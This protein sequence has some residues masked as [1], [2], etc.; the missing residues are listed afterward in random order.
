MN[1]N[2][3]DYV[4]HPSH[5]LGTVVTI[6]EMTFSADQTNLFYRVDFSSKTVWV[7]V[8]VSKISK[9]RPVTEKSA[10]ASYR[11]I[12]KNSPLR[13]EDDF[14]KRQIEIETRLTSGSFKAICEIVRDLTARNKEKNLNNHDA[15][16]LK[17][18]RQSLVNE[19]AAAGEISKSEAEAEIERLLLNGY[20]PKQ[21]VHAKTG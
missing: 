2:R 20:S 7:P 8:D 16:V 4:V 21:A 9:L 10:L 14:R 18:L 19:W 13:L 3:G 15:Q 5:G 6:E 11:K 17:Q 12:L 1:F